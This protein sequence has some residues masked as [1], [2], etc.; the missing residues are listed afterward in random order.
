MQITANICKHLQVLCL[1]HWQAGSL[2]LCHPESPSN[3]QAEVEYE[4]FYYRR[5]LIKGITCL[6]MGFP[7]GSVGKEPISNAGDAG[8]LGLIPGSGRYPGVEEMA[9]HSSIP[10]WRIPRTE[11]PGRL[12]SV[13]SQRVRHD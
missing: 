12:Q 4:R 9:T 7:G 1:L 5:H 10:A 11:E 13:G 3:D 2:P 6:E 8:D